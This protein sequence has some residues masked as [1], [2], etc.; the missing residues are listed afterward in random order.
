LA[1]ADSRTRPP[2]PP[3]R[4]NAEI[5]EETRGKLL[6]A[7]RRA[8]AARGYADA[9]ADEIGEAAGL[10][11]GAL[12]YQFQD[13]RGLFEAVA[14]AMLAELAERIARRT[15]ENDPA[16]TEELERGCDLL[17]EAYG[18]PEIQTILLRDAPVVLGWTTWHRMQDEAG[19]VALL[20]HALE[21][22]A[23]AGWITAE[24]AEPI[25]RLLLGA[26]TQAGVAI[27]EAE[28]RTRALT[29]YRAELRALV[30]GLI[31]E[32]ARDPRR[33]PG[34]PLRPRRGSSRR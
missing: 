18:E 23:T 32:D 12:H 24:R 27:A 17:L 14:Q 28:D 10:T 19:L 29:R 25:A 21:H 30:R 31:P 9:S 20:R 26:L 33:P 4:T 22:W 11:R 16:E 2:R 13:K 6:A 8:F 3:R 34:T 15:M 1:S 5:S 7:G